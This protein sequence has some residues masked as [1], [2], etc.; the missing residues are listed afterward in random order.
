MYIFFFTTDLNSEK[1]PYQKINIAIQDMKLD[2]MRSLIG[3]NIAAERLKKSK[4]SS[5]FPNS[6]DS[7]QMLL[8]SLIWGLHSLPKC[9]FICNWKAVKGFI[10]AGGIGRG[11]VNR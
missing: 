8:S 9:Q 2:M 11:E 5:R 6:I 1:N 4:F 10:L 7:D 3:D